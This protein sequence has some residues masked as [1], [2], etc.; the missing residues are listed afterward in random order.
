MSVRIVDNQGF[1]CLGIFF[2]NLCMTLEK[3][4]ERKHIQQIRSAE[5]QMQ[6]MLR[7]NADLIAKDIALLQS[8]QLTAPEKY[9]A[10]L[11]RNKRLQKKI[12]DAFAELEISLIDEI[13]GQTTIQWNLA[14]TKNNILVND[15][16]AGKVDQIYNNLNLDALKAFHNRN[17]SGQ[18]L[19]DRIHN[20]TELNKQLYNDY[21]GSGITQGKSSI[22]IAREL[23]KIN[24]NPKN[25]T[26]FDKK[27]N[28]TKLGKISPILQPNAKGTGIYRSP[29]KNLFRVTR[30]ETNAAYRLS[31]QTRI[32]QLDFVV[33]YEVHLS[34]AH[35]I[36][37]VCDFMAGKYPKDFVFS[38]WHSNC[39]CYVT[40]ILKTRDEFRRGVKSKNEITKIHK[41][42]QRY[43]KTNKK[44][45]WDWQ[46]ENF[47]KSGTPY[48]KVGG[49]SKSI[50]PY[51]ISIASKDYR[52]KSKILV[53][54]A[55]VG[56]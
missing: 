18:L 46:K 13:N 12:N 37:D 26:V 15:Y 23:N 47:T 45:Y 49:P 36:A 44:Q 10:Q 39:L 24:D 35:N 21:I 41:S 31:D 9:G 29:L 33:G 19:S 16:I 5:L 42:A 38:G 25:V 34:G 48:K 54:A 2:V 27:G 52:P 7:V 30:T 11:K 8:K 53:K 40:T 17:T 14:N 56:G 55:K 3:R 4:Y 28:P 50:E 51:K 22:K 32:R 20:L 1:I 6:R 43:Q